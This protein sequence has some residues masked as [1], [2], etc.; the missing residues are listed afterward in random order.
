MKVE[1][2]YILSAEKKCSSGRDTLRRPFSLHIVHP[3]CSG[4]IFWGNCSTSSWNNIRHFSY[5]YTCRDSI[6]LPWWN[7]WTQ[8]QTRSPI[9]SHHKEISKRDSFI[10]LVPKN[11]CPG[12]YCGS[13]T[14]QCNC[15]G[16]TQLVCYYLGL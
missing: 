7:Y 15:P 1:L 3:K 10:G 9:I 11:P 12:F 5:I 14:F 13:F 4:Y 16:V 2:I 6:A 8:L